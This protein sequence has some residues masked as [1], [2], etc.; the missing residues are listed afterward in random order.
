[1][2]NINKF[3]VLLLNRNKLIKFLYKLHEITEIYWGTKTFADHCIYIYF[4]F[5]YFVALEMS[6]EVFESCSNNIVYKIMIVLVFRVS[7][8]I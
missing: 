7:K 5:S 1:M 8:E 3:F 4:F 6:D 2:K